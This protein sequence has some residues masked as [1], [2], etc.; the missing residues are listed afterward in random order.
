M[1]PPLRDCSAATAFTAVTFR[2]RRCPTN[3]G[4]ASAGFAVVDS[5]VALMILTVTLVIALQAAQAARQAASSALEM[6]RAEGLFRF[7]LDSQPPAVGALVGQAED[8]KWRLD[9]QL[10]A[11]QAG[12]TSA[13]ICGRTLQLRNI[14]S[15]H[16]YRVD[17]AVVCPTPQQ[18]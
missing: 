2:G 9:T 11:P 1:S 5:L 17:T 3:R 15:G 8:F 14:R 6:R 18:T 16:R 13:Q 4:D 12:T 10:S 7:L